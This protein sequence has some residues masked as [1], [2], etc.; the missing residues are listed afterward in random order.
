[1]RG[2]VLFCSPEWLLLESA[3]VETTGKRH[4]PCSDGVLG[5]HIASDRLWSS[6]TSWSISSAASFPVCVQGQGCTFAILLWDG[7][8]VSVSAL[9]T[10][11]RSVVNTGAD[12]ESMCCAHWIGEK[13]SIIYRE[14]HGRWE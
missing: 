14:P 12:P 3:S 4:L 9:V 6:L 10:K 11:S 2:G 7:F 1:M 13:H 8:K 5:G